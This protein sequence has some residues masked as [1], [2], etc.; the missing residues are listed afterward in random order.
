M[1]N[2][3]SELKIQIEAWI[4][5]VSEQTIYLKRTLRLVFVSA[6]YWTGL[7]FTFLIIQGFLPAAIVYL[8]RFLVND[9]VE[10]ID[11]SGEWESLQAVIWSGSL[12]ALA[13]VLMEV[14]SV[15]IGWVRKA[16]AAL[17]IDY[18]AGLIHK[19]S[20]AVDLAFYE[21]PDYYDQLYRARDNAGVR[22][23]ELL[24]SGGSLLQNGITLAALA[25]I[26]LPYG[27]WLPP[28]L[29]ISALPGL[30]IVLIHHRRHHTWWQQTTP[31]RRWAEYF[32]TMLTIDNNAAELRLF[33]LGTHF[34]NGFQTLRQKLRNEELKLVKSESMSRLS[35]T[36]F[37]LII[38]GFV[39]IWMVW[40]ALQGLATL[41]D[42]ALFYQ[43]FNQGQRLLQTLL[44]NVGQIYSNNLFLKHLFEFLDLEP[45]IVD[46]KEP[47]PNP[48]PLKEG[49]RFNN[50]TFAYPG[51]KRTVL[52]EFDL[53]IPV[54]KM[55]AVVGENG[56]GKS[57]LIKLLCRFY[58]PQMGQIELD[59]IDIKN[60]SVKKLRA[61]FS[62]LF[63][64]PVDYHAAVAH[65]IAI[66]NLGS[67]PN[68][69]EIV[70][71]AKG[72]GAHEFILT[73][74]LEYETLLG[75]MV[76]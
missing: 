65:N 60:L 10:V 36:L 53:N 7:W 59:G 47:I 27:A 54:G 43:A 62:V 40:R 4:Q 66:G 57:T 51:S 64:I 70:A 15:F 20:T 73:L 3:I 67:N 55:I 34:K 31:D 38:S 48:L 26:L 5:Q 72:A 52:N 42:L 30:I 1:S 68:K 63:Q 49:I 13:I 35:V 56:A 76:C 37:A 28:V 11:T 32:D 23:L 21:S 2:T 58:D 61:L 9:L 25:A 17:L 75:K 19:Q 22:S 69:E 46:P 44:G 29:F 41:G 71:A 18:L 33:D 12:I 16:Q 6:G 8:T 39:M 50:V 14:I 74:P 45:Q 24:E